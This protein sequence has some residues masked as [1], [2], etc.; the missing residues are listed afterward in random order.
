MIN[1]D[2]PNLGVSPDGLITD[3]S[4]PDPNGILVLSNTET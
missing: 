4:S 1:P 3:V 2:F